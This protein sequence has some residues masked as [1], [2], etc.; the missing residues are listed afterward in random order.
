MES[1][2]KTTVINT[3]EE[4]RAILTASPHNSHDIKRAIATIDSLVEYVDGINNRKE[5][6]VE[7]T[8]EK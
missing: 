5:R 6:G 4:I 2:K 3:L 7:G 8:L 1:H